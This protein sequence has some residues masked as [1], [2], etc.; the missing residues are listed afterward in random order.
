MKLTQRDGNFVWV[1]YNTQWV[2]ILMQRVGCSMTAREDKTLFKLPDG[3]YAN[4]DRFHNC[5]VIDG[6]GWYPHENTPIMA[7][8]TFPSLTEQIKI[9]VSKTFTN[10]VISTSVV[11]PRGYFI[12]DGV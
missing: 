12:I 3:I 8:I 1:Y 2:Y 6:T 7:S 4:V 10:G 11:F 5:L 9:R